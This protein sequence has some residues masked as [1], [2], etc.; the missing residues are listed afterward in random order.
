[1]SD[2]DTIWLESAEYQAERDYWVCVQNNAIV[3]RQRV[4]KF[5]SNQGQ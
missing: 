5:Y 1:M 2:F 3:G 4:R